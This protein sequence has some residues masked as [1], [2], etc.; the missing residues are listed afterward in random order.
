[1]Q[2][3]WSRKWIHLSHDLQMH[4]LRCSDMRKDSPLSITCMRL[5]CL[6]L[7]LTW[8]FVRNSCIHCMQYLWPEEICGGN[9]KESR[10]QG[11]KSMVCQNASGE[12]LHRSWFSQMFH[13]W[14]K[15]LPQSGRTR[16]PPLAHKTYELSSSVTLCFCH[17]CSWLVCTVYKSI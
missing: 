16:K 11:H 4:N 2:H 5:L 10:V 1:M 6:K 13:L 14:A 17:L 7:P 8:R 9:T 3:L 12:T 15:R